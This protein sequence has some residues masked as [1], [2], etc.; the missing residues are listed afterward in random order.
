MWHIIL[1]LHN[2]LTQSL[3]QYTLIISESLWVRNLSVAYLVL[4]L[5][6]LSQT[7]IKVSAGS[8]CLTVLRIYFLSPRV[9][10]RI[11]ATVGCWT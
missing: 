8:S 9:V 3:K 1:L 5:Q 11:E 6:T 4:I 10:G 2:K 7:T